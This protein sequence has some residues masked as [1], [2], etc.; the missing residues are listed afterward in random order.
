LLHVAHAQVLLSYVEHLLMVAH[1]EHRHVAELYA[2]HPVIV[3]HVAH[4]H[5]L[6]VYVVHP[7]IVVH[8]EQ[9]ALVPEPT[10]WY[11]LVHV[12]HAQFAVLYA[13]QLLTPPHVAHAHVAEL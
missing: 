11:P 2:E 5:A 7:L 9:V 12:V 6:D 13:A 8:C 1:V 3:V 10:S 4:V